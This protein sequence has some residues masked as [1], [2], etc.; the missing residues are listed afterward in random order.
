MSVRQ[1]P[2]NVKLEGARDM[3]GLWLGERRRTRRPS[4]KCLGFSRWF[5]ISFNPQKPSF[6]KPSPLIKCPRVTVPLE[7]NLTQGLARWL[8]EHVQIKVRKA[9]ETSASRERWDHTSRNGT[10]LAPSLAHE[11]TLAHQDQ[12]RRSRAARMPPPLL[13]RRHGH[14][15]EGPA[16]YTT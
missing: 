13:L 16:L 14:L 3:A 2:A 12:E 15:L 6:W 11:T 9:A 8:F 4:I 10:C 7:A 1:F 5:V